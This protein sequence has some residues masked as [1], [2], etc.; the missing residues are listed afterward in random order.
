MCHSGGGGGGGGDGD[1]WLQGDMGQLTDWDYGD[2]NFRYRLVCHSGGGGGGGGV[3]GGDGG[4]GDGGGSDG[5]GDGGD[6]DGD[7]WLHGGLGQLTDRVYG[8]TNFR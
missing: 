5:D 3:G 2:T 8:D 7:S 4:D 6:G 1:S